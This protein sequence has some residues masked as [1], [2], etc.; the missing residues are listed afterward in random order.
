MQINGRR[1]KWTKRRKI[2]IH[3]KANRYESY[4]TIN[5]RHYAEGDLV[6]IWHDLYLFHP[7]GIFTFFMI[8]P[9]FYFYWLT[10]SFWEKRAWPYQSLID[11]SSQHKIPIVLELKNVTVC[12]IRK[13]PSS[14]AHIDVY[15]LRLGLSVKNKFGCA[16][17]V[18]TL[19]AN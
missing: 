7:G 14:V 5:R 1:R 10:W 17:S 15:D 8:M 4:E 3:R 6:N 2:V 11:A 13:L 12:Q 16:L 9:L 19:W 18:H